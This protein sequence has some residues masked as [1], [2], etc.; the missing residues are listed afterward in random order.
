M[1]VNPVLTVFKCLNLVTLAV[2][3]FVVNTT[4]ALNKCLSVPCSE[5]GVRLDSAVQAEAA[6]SGRLVELLRTS[7][8]T[9]GSG[10]EVATRRSKRSVFLHS[11][12]RI[13]PQ[14]A[15]SEVLASHQAYYQLRGT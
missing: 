8:Q 11:G 15:I 5:S 13:C 10:F 2:C 3:P 1:T 9:E 12:V 14:E 6:G 4:H 7:T